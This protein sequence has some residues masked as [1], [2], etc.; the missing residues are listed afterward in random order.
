MLV[1]GGPKEGTV[2]VADCHLWK[3][4]KCEDTLTV[5]PE[6]LQIITFLCKALK[7]GVDE[8]YPAVAT[9]YTEPMVATNSKGKVQDGGRYFDEYCAD[10]LK[11]RGERS[12]TLTTR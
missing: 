11:A 2:G 7:G 9:E 6:I 4:S 8:L 3:I 5:D 10:M 12:M 1:E